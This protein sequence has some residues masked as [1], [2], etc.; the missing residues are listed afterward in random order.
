LSAG[1]DEV[2]MKNVKSMR[3]EFLKKPAIRYDREIFFRNYKKVF[4]S[5]HLQ[6]ILEAFIS[7]SLLKMNESS[8]FCGFFYCAHVLWVR[9]LDFYIQSAST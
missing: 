6:R 5:M 1:L 9:S 3:N 2:L 8:T 7:S 4:F